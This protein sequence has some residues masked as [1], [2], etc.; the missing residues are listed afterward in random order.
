MSGGLAH[1]PS[2]GRDCG[3]SSVRR[4]SR[5]ASRPHPRVR[6]HRN[7]QHPTPYHVAI[8]RAFEGHRSTH[9]AHRMHVDSSSSNAVPIA[10]GS[11]SAAGTMEIRS[12]GHTST[13][14]PHST[15]ASTSNWMLEKHRRHRCASARASASVNPNSTS[16][17]PIRRSVADWGH[18]G[19]ESGRTGRQ[20]DGNCAVAAACQQPGSHRHR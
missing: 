14:R 5:A 11:K 6:Q 20:G 18:H 19:G 1:V 4:S 17:R 8:D 9:S 3:T 13:H 16:A 2:C 12:N 7:R 15:Q 10:P